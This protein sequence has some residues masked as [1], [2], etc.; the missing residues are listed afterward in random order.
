MT[1]KD[2]LTHNLNEMEDLLNRHR[3]AIAQLGQIGEE[4]F[5]PPV[6]A[7]EAGQHPL[8]QVVLE[9]IEELEISRKAFKSKQLETLRKKMIRVLA[10]SG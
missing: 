7:I 10:E 9:A 5:L 8:K 4:H 1:I 6:Y 3:N 2:S